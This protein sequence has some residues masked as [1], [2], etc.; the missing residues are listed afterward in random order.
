M[1]ETGDLTER[2]EI[3]DRYRALCKAFVVL[4][5]IQRAWSKNEARLVPEEG[6]EDDYAEM[7]RTMQTLRRMMQEL[8]DRESVLLM[9]MYGLKAKGNVVSAP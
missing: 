9:K 2:V 5:G 4:E 8:R 3:Q 7:D 1:I 6:R